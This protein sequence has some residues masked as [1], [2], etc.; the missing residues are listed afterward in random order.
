VNL[1]PSE[2]ESVLLQHPQLADVAV[3]GIPHPD[4]G[5]QLLA[6]VVPADPALPPAGS[7]LEAF[8]RESLASYKIPRRFEYLAELPRNE[9]QKV[10]KKALRRPY[11]DSD[12]TI[13]G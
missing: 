8:C 9:M 3:I 11:W 2:S 10:D 1:Y 5:E 12:R 13:A 7:D 6:L 4:L